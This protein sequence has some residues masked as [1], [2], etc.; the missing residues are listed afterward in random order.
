M[1]RHV[2]AR[3]HAGL[4]NEL[5]R[6][7]REVAADWRVELGVPFH[8]SRHSFVAPAGDDAVLKIAPAED[9]ESDHEADALE[10]WNGDGAVRLLRRDPNRKAMLLERARP[11]TDLSQ[12]AEDEAIA[13]A[14]DISARLWRRPPPGAPFRR[15]IDLAPAWLEAVADESEL[16]FHAR[17]ALDA[18]GSRTTTVVHG[19]FHHHNV[20]RHGD[21]YVAIDPKAA[22]GEPEFDVPPFLWN[23]IGTT[24]TVERTERRIAAFVA[25]GL[26]DARIRSWSI[27]RGVY[28]GFIQGPSIG[29]PPQLAV[30][31]MLTA[32]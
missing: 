5:E 30:A 13:V 16:V 6:V 23:P 31:R 17:R 7:A 32:T 29:E 19:D 18:L 22:I 15:V 9:E 11:G 26:D 4:M 14:V 24:P 25:A 20:L 28:L 27:I 8:L 1:S 3:P 10:L 21:R 12:V 2:A